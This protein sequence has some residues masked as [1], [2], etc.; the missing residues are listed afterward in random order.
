MA[1]RGKCF[2]AY[3]L[4]V[5]LCCSELQCVAVYCLSGKR[6]GADILVVKLCCSVMQRAAVCCSVLRTL[7]ERMFGAHILVVT[8]CC[9]ELQCGSVNRSVLHYVAMCCGSWLLQQLFWRGHSRRNLLLQC[10]A[11][12]C[13]MCSVLQCVAVCCSVL[14]CVADRVIVGE[15]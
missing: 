6:F 10:I 15:C 4:I 1:L 9:S 3:I 2:C 13:S 12:C 8:R 5:T 14:Q 7:S 11:V